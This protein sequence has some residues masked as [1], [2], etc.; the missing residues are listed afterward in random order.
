MA[1]KGNMPA[2][3]FKG[4]SDEWE[5]NKLEELALVERGKFTVRPRN[6]PRY[7]GGNI[8]FV[9]TGDIVNSPLYLSHISQTLNA[10]GLKVSKLF[11]RN[12]VLITIAANIG[13]TTITNFDVACTDSVVAIQLKTDIASSV[14]IKFLLDTKKEELDSKATQNAQ[15]NIN[16]Q[17][18]KPLLFAT[19]SFAEQTQIGSYFQN[20][21]NL[22]SLHQA[23]VNKLVNLKKA[24]LEKMFPKPGADVPEIRFKGFEGAWEEKSLGK[25]AIV[26]TGFP[27]DSD[28]FSFDGEYLV[29]TN[30]NI[31]NESPHVDNTTGNRI[32][33][34]NE[35][36]IREYVLNINDILV[37][38]DGTVGRTAKVADTKQILA[39][40]V[41]RLTANSNP[42]FL[43]YVL[44][45]GDFYKNM[46]LIS[47]G[48]TIKHISLNEISS[49]LIKIPKIKEEEQKI[50]FY[51]KNLDKLITLHRSELNKLN[52]LKKACL[53][54]MFV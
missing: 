49:Y 3:R 14:W 39:Q 31:Q 24:M 35:T 6:D 12:T 52:N 45:T 54:K 28:G 36:I 27:F 11:P 5:E 44:N 15:K 33:I 40:R 13:D 19:P 16:L 51:F 30:G 43:Y 20:L 25:I 2:I 53:E 46:V 10:E 48:G 26:R 37:T 32:N 41:G 18:L 50:G 9:Q 47:S 38:M 4:F 34:K 42:D 23:K 8:P 21:D 7:F 22:I 1:E 29:I 17:V